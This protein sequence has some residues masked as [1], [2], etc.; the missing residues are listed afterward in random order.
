MA[1]SLNEEE[2]RLREK[3]AEWLMK[4]FDSFK[5]TD[6]AYIANLA[7]LTPQ[8]LRRWS[9]V[10]EIKL[11]S[12]KELRKVLLEKLK[13]TEKEYGWDNYKFLQ[14]LERREYKS[15]EDLIECLKKR[16]EI[17]AQKIK[18]LNDRLLLLISRRGVISRSQKRVLKAIKVLFKICYDPVSNF[19]LD[20][21]WRKS[22]AEWMKLWE[23]GE[24]AGKKDPKYNEA[25]AEFKKKRESYINLYNEALTTAKG[26]LKLV[27]QS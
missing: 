20:Q 27:Q 8:E 10:K 24:V 19:D 6:V 7:S 3:A 17:Q 23:K 26:L 9:S 18:A 21:A 5:E 25:V 12:R 4:L 14:R 13:N 22:F 15:V 1:K 16:D 11:A 2:A